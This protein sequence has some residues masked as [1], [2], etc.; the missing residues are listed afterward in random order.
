MMI[1]FVY[2]F[3]S[4]FSF[5]LFLLIII[6]LFI[7]YL[8]NDGN[9]VVPYVTMGILVVISAACLF[10]LPETKGRPLADTLTTKTEVEYMD[11]I[12]NEDGKTSE[13]DESRAILD[14]SPV[15]Y[16]A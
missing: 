6:Y 7:I 11:I 1:L 8:Q 13:A 3:I 4:L 16:K 5:F 15:I 10:L 12:K 9:I 2:V 14:E